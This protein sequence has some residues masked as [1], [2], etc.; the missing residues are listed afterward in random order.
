MTQLLTLQ[1]GYA[2]LNLPFLLL[3]YVDKSCA[4]ATLLL[5]LDWNDMADLQVT[6]ERVAIRQLDIYPVQDV[7]LVQA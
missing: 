5:L 4:N 7:S 1:A 2:A 6:V 3:G